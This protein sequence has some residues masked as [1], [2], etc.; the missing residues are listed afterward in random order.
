MKKIEDLD[1]L[2][3]GAY[4]YCVQSVAE[5]LHKI[6]LQIKEL[7]TAL[8]SETKS[9]AGDKHETGRAM[10]QLEREKL[11]Q[12]LAEVEKTQQLLFKVPKNRDA[13]TVGLGSLVITDSSI[14]YL[15]I[16]AGEYKNTQASVYCISAA[17]PIGKLVFGKSVGDTFLFNGKS[18]ILLTIR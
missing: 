1:A 5:K 13:K 3:I 10:I 18:S 4:Q 12:Q 14:Y 6:Q 16:S 17:T 11:G 15:A 8:T 9:S 7:E 2:K